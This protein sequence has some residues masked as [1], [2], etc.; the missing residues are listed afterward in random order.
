[1]SLQVEAHEKFDHIKIE[2]RFQT[3]EAEELQKV[4]SSAIKNGSDVYLDLKDVR[5]VSA[6]GLGILV[7]AARD[8]YLAQ[9]LWVSSISPSLKKLLEDTE[10]IDLFHFKEIDQR[11]SD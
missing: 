5:S 8:G 10:L 3:E 9:H 1:M 6:A 11:G 7:L 4:F 2:S